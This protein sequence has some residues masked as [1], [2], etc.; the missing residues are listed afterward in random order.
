LL[1]DFTMLD[2]WTAFGPSISLACFELAVKIRRLLTGITLLGSWKLLGLLTALLLPS[3]ILYDSMQNM[4]IVIIEKESF[5]FLFSE[6][7][8]NLEI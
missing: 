6:L 5:I 1:T 8:K 3:A 4:K 7:R 2:C